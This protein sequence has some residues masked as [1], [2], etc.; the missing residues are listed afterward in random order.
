MKT[1]LLIVI[2]MQ[3]D[4]VTGALG[5]KEAQRIV[6][7]IARLVDNFD[8]AVLFTQDTHYDDY[9]STQEG[10]NLPVVHCIKDTKGWEIVSEINTIDKICFTKS[11]F[12]ST[13]L[14][15]WI[16]LEQKE[17]YKG[18][19]EIILCGVCTGICV[20]A[21]AVLLKTVLPETKI[22]VLKDYCACVTPESH[23]NAINAMKLLQINVE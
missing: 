14:A 1:K 18:L 12:G 4:F 19:D 11:T 8:G 6:K 3:N 17:L 7:P 23:E 20:I 15:N 9:L 21:N 13:E 10:K 5:T 22:T 16:F 2:D